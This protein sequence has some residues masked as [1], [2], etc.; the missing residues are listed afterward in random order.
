[1]NKAIRENARRWAVR[2]I[3]KVHTVRNWTHEDAHKYLAQAYLAGARSMD[4]W[5]RKP[6]NAASVIVKAGGRAF[7]PVS[8]FD[9]E[10]KPV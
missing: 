3:K 6:I 1:M 4:E 5:H 9:G 7:I 10:G 8:D 2:L